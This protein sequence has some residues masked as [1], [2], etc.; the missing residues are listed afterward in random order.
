MHLN[1]TEFYVAS[2]LH[3][4]A[5]VLGF[6][7]HEYVHAMALELLLSA[8]KQY[9]SI[10]LVDGHMLGNMFNGPQINFHG[11][12]LDIRGIDCLPVMLNLPSKI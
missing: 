1:C 12:P 3:G 9:M 6:N 2:H 10:V 7:P 11:K 8:Q 4:M 5:S